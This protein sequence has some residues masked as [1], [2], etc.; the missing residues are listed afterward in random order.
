VVLLTVFALV[1]GRASRESASLDPD[2]PG[3]PHYHE[4]E[5][6]QEPAAP[7]ADGEPEAA[8]LPGQERVPAAPATPGS[9]PRR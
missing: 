8:P 1:Q 4:E 6:S 7:S 2:D 3:S 5:E 9:D